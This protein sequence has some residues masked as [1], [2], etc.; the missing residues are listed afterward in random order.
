MAHL[1]KNAKPFQDH[2]EEPRCKPC[3]FD[4]GCAPLSVYAIVPGYLW[5]LELARLGLPLENC[6][7][8]EL[9][10]TLSLTWKH[11]TSFLLPVF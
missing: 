3:Q 2:V 6:W 10:Y 7:N 9:V 1:F 4:Q 5:S 11:V 8:L